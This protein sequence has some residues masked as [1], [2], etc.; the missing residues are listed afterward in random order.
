MCLSQL[1]AVESAHSQAH[2]CHVADGG[3]SVGNAGQDLMD[4]HSRHKKT[5]EELELGLITH[6]LHV[7]SGGSEIDAFF[8]I[9][10]MNLFCRC[11]NI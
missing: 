1:H 2:H 10:D 6:L 8:H 11:R 7:Y 3:M 5:N 4:K 9:E